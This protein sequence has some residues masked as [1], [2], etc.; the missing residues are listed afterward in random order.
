VSHL[1]FLGEVKV[2]LVAKLL[3]HTFEN[4]VNVIH[5]I[6]VQRIIVQHANTSFFIKIFND[7]LSNV[8]MSVQVSYLYCPKIRVL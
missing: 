5:I 1:D 4:F 3:F 2:K 7:N 6:L 8:C